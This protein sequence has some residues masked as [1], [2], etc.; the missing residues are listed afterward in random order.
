VSAKEEDSLRVLHVLMQPTRLKIVRLLMDS[1][2]PL[3]AAEIA[4]KIGADIRTV[5]FHLATLA[6][7]GLVEEEYAEIEKAKH[8]AVGMRQAKFF[9]VTPKAKETINRLS[10]SS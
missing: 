6:E 10:E 8:S 3:Y 5:A 2:R 1:H 9:R 4:T 7:S